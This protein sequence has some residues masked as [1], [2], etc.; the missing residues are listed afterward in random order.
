MPKKPP[1]I[2]PPPQTLPHDGIF[3]RIWAT[4]MAILTLLTN[5]FRL[6]P[7]PSLSDWRGLTMGHRG[8]R[9][10]LDIPENSL[11]SFMFAIEQG[12]DAI[13]LDC[14]LTKDGVIVCMHDNTVDRTCHGSGYVKDMTFQLINQ[15]SF[16]PTGR[17]QAEQEPIE[18]EAD[19]RARWNSAEYY[20][21]SP[22]L[23]TTPSADHSSN[24]STITSTKKSIKLPVR[25]PGGRPWKPS[26]EYP[27]S[28]TTLSVQ[29]N[30]A[31]FTPSL[32]GP[33]SL[34]QVILLAI[35]YKV[36]VMIEIK[37]FTNTPLLCEQLHALY[38]KYPYLLNHSYCASF[39]PFHLYSLRC[40]NPNIATCFLYCR[41]AIEWY[42]LDQSHEME[43]PY[44]LNIRPFRWAADQ[45]LLYVAPRALIH[46]VQPS[47]VGVHNQLLTL[48]LCESMRALDILVDVWC[49]NR[50]NEAIHWREQG[51]L[52]TTDYLF[53]HYAQPQ[54]PMTD[55]RLL[56][57]IN[58][59]STIKVTQDEMKERGAF[60]F[61]VNHGSPKL[62]NSTIRPRVPVHISN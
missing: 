28:L 38:Q 4:I 61:N 21:D 42:R 62:V 1:V 14:S 17:T 23:A 50:I 29:S 59:A 24:N 56:R 20:L 32:S 51:C 11:V 22:K 43:L 58:K 10:N 48:E 26:I 52:I 60:N 13:E 44:L 47:A 37:E 27:H 5:R 57:A 49:V 35:H 36:R 8:C 7:S 15:L 3:S 41:D 18:P 55:V 45:L 9:T 25:T 39:N 46:F 2:T 16:R 30:N 31:W 19:K 34:E 54:T 33:P 53:P 12:A 6:P 40:I